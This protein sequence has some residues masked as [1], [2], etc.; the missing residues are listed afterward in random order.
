M[1]I[2]RQPL[3]RHQLPTMTRVKA[4]V[5]KE[6]AKVKA[7]V[8][9]KIE[10]VALCVTQRSHAHLLPEPANPK[11]AIGLDSWANV[12]LIH[13]GAHKKNQGYDCSLSLA[14]GECKCY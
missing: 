13:Q 5:R 4:K 7:K 8:K 3:R 11:G 1:L 12:H 14:H 9:V 10:P 6:K 2:I